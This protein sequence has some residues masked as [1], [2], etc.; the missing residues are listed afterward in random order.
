M[1]VFLRWRQSRRKC[2]VSL[3]YGYLAIFTGSLPTCD[4][5]TLEDLRRDGWSADCLLH[6]DDTL[7]A[8]PDAP[9]DHSHHF[10]NHVHHGRSTAYRD[11]QH[12]WNAG[13]LDY[14]WRKQC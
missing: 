11:K 4:P 2:C 6:T 7:L 9:T 12:H 14:Y 10:N 13:W 5:V 1:R 8:D 3:N